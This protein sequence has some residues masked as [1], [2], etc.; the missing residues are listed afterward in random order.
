MSIGLDI[1]MVASKTSIQT[2]QKEMAILANNLANVNNTD[3]HRQEIV[4]QENTLIPGRFAYYGSGVSVSNVVRHYD[5]ALETSLKASTSADGYT[6]AYSKMLRQLEDLVIPEGTNYL[7]ESIQDFAN[8]VQDLAT[9]PES[10]VARNALLGRATT[11]AEK[12]NRQYNQ[13]D[14][15]RTYLA[16]DSVQGK[17]AIK[18]DIDKLNSLAYEMSY[19]NDQI[20]NLEMNAY[21]NQKAND[22]RD[23][24]DTVVMEMA[25]LTNLTVTEEANF[26][27]TVEI[28]GHSFVNGLLDGS[29]QVD[30]INF[31]MVKN[32]GTIQTVAAPPADV[33][34]FT[35]PANTYTAAEM[36]GR[37]IVVGGEERIITNFDPATETVTV[38]E[39]PLTVAPTA[40][41][42]TYTIYDPTATFNSD[43]ST[44]GFNDGE[45]HAFTDARQY[46]VDQMHTLHAFSMDFADI[47]N[48]IHNTGTYPAGAGVTYDLDGNPAAGTFFTATTPGGMTVNITDPRLIAA[49]TSQNETG[50]GDNMIALWEAMNT[51][52]TNPPTT[53]IALNN[54]SL[55]NFS[56]R[57]NGELA[58]AVDNANAEAETTESTKSM[59]QN[60]V[61]EVSAVSTDEEMTKMLETQ[62]AYQAAAKVIT[63]LSQMLDVMVSIV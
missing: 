8:A 14:E 46:V 31:T 42:T 33:T 26:K 61:F 35:I 51:S 6:Q 55:L 37:K 24:R 21:N 53:V 36:I 18:D 39:P 29:A 2:R 59:F 4:L 41:V 5:E 20:S 56:D 23:Q 49:S 54:D 16:E 47:V 62:Q 7:S 28:D 48:S 3:Y 9:T 50:N 11:V 27:Y 45:I 19:L 15:I 22:L 10:L 63:V 44:V 13:M 40:G 52:Q 1:A 43:S 38:D 58:V 34:T 17:G 30:K 25:E 57:F 12:F 32:A 60:A